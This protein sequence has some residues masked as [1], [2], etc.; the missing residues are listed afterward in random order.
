MTKRRFLLASTLGY[1]LFLATPGERAQIVEISPLGIIA[2]GDKRPARGV[3]QV[4]ALK[5]IVRVSDIKGGPS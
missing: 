3:R 4:S 1:F 5:V 2:P